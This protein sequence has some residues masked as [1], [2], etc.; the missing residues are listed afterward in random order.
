MLTYVCTQT[1]LDGSQ[2]GLVCRGVM[3][4]TI[5]EYIV[6]ATYLIADTYT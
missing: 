5:P 6:L 1:G 4:G 2:V 3:S